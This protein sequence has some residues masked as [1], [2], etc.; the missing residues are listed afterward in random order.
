MSICSGVHADEVP[1][2]AA[3]RP[4]LEPER[5][6]RLRPEKRKRAIAPIRSSACTTP[7]FS[8]PD[9]IC[10]LTF[11]PPKPRGVPA[12]VPDGAR[13]TVSTNSI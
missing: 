8:N 1:V 12:G 10:F 2:G 9:G 6:V 3:D 5:L 11:F 7:I 13:I 4:V